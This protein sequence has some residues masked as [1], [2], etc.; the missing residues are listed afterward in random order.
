MHSQRLEVVDL[1]TD[2]E[3]LDRGTRTRYWEQ[4]YALLYVQMTIK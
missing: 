4:V 2:F 3:E 1:K